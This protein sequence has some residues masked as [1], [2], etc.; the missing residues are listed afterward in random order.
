MPWLRRVL[1]ETGLDRDGSW[2][3]R[4]LTET[5]LDRDGSW[6]RRV[7]TD[8]CIEWK[9]LN[10]FKVSRLRRVL[11]CLNMSWW[12][13]ILTELCLDLDRTWHFQSVETNTCLDWDVSWP[14]RV[15]T[16]TCLDQDVSWPRCVL[17][18]KSLNI[19]KVSRLRRVL[20]CLNMSW[21]RHI[22]TELCL[23]LDRT[24]H[25]QSVE[26]NTCLDW[27]VSW[28]RRVLTETG[29]DRD[30]SW[31]RR[32]LTETCLDRDGSWPIFVLSVK[33][34]KIFKVLRLRYVLTCFHNTHSFSILRKYWHYQSV[35]ISFLTLVDNV[36]TPTPTLNYL[37]KRQSKTK[38]YFCLN[39]QKYCT[40]QISTTFSDF[41]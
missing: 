24:W 15:L 32:V 16:E 8:I 11:R 29:L 25:F 41:S 12:R 30:G 33:S 9:S 37:K 10:I 39:Q 5:G 35:K 4:V 22:L 27:D 2:P 23:D 17:S 3:R 26:T 40:S 14:R 18:V 1:T 19:F 7:L 6:P 34:L 31:P 20:R 38:N 36:E 13:H 21:R 28:P